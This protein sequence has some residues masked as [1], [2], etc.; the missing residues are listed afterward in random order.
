[1]KKFL[2]FMFCTFVSSNLLAADSIPLMTNFGENI[3]NYNRATTKIATAGVLSQKGIDQL[4][5]N[6]FKTIIDLRTE[7]EGIKDEKEYIKQKKSIQYINI[8][9]TGAGISEE[10]LAQFTK[11]IEEARKP[12]IIHCASGNRAGAMWTSYRLSKG[13][14]SDIAFE[15]GFTAGMSQKMSETIKDIKEIVEDVKEAKPE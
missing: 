7:Q 13:I 10:Q 3:V 4:A 14:P 5:E 11:V 8:P 9:V 15:E 6:G 12:V 1:M 2:V